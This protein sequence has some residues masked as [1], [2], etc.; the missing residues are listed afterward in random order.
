MLHQGILPAHP[1][2][3]RFLRQLRYV[4]VDEMHAY[5]G[6]FGSHVARRDAPLGRLARHYG[7]LAATC[8]AA[9]P[10]AIPASWRSV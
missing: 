5:R 7:G 3:A 2:W 9:R 1:K 4:V 6:I 8:C 10:S